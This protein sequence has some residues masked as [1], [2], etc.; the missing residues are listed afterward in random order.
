M[1]ESVPPAPVSISDGKEHVVAHLRPDL[2]AGMP[3]VRVTA[4]ERGWRAEI[5]DLDVSYR[6]PSLPRVDR[7]VRDLLGLSLTRWVAYEFRTGDAALDRL[8][9]ETRVARFTAQL[10]EERARQATRDL[11]AHVVHHADLSIR[12]LAVM[13]GLSHQRIHQLRHGIG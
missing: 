5:P 2:E 4:D 11:L 10:A 1:L 3:L 9:A 13:L 6:A 7:W 12:D 8:V